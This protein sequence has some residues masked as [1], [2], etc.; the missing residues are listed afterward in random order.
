MAKKHTFYMVT[1]EGQCI[2]KR[3]RG[4]PPQNGRKWHS[5]RGDAWE[6][7][8]RSYHWFEREHPVAGRKLYIIR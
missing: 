7:A 6:A 3:F 8:A 2:A 5:W 4:R 1:R